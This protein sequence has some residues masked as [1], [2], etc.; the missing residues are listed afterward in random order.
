M[1]M[2]RLTV[3]DTLDLSSLIGECYLT[4]LMEEFVICKCPRHRLHSQ[5][6]LWYHPDIINVLITNNDLSTS[7]QTAQGK[8]YSMYENTKEGPLELCGCGTAA[9]IANLEHK[10]TCEEFQ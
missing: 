10:S 3:L 5:Q 1:S 9:E 8:I 4:I 2:T 7:E 6:C